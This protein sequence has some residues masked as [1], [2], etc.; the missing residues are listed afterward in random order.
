MNNSHYD[1]D[2]IGL[3]LLFVHGGFAAPPQLVLEMNLLLTGPA[4][5]TQKTKLPEAH[6]V[7]H[8]AALLL[9]IQTSTLHYPVSYFSIQ[10][11]PQ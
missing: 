9:M 5:I 10:A 4:T 1:G 3:P 11:Q 2:P 8:T 6:A 7:S